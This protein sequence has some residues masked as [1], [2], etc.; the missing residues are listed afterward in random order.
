MVKETLELLEV[1]N[2]NLNKI[3]KNNSLIIQPI[4]I[5]NLRI[6]YLIN[7]LRDDTELCH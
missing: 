3:S 4:K 5:K 6:F 7:I 1:G 2:I